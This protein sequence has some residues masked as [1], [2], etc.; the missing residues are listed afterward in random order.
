MKAVEIKIDGITQRQF[1]VFSP[2][3]KK[4]SLDIRDIAIGSHSLEVRP[5]FADG[6]FGEAY[7]R[8]FIV[9]E[10][11]VR[12]RVYDAANQLVTNPRINILGF[13]QKDRKVTKLRINPAVV[14]G[15]WMANLDFEQLTRSYNKIRCS[16]ESR[17][18]DGRGMFHS[19]SEPSVQRER[20][21]L[22]HRSAMCWDL[23]PDKDSWLY[24]NH[25]D[26]WKSV[27]GVQ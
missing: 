7:S 9:P 14:N 19:I 8:D 13:S 15:V 17:L 25:P 2:G 20:R 10:Y 16:V 12:I 11:N 1:T 24:E 27:G 6:T 4:V 21:I 22:I 3:E 18:S 26:S 23:H 5:V